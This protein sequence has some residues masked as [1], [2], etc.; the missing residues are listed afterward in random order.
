ME[1][2]K[3][4]RNFRE[5]GLTVSVWKN[6]TEGGKIYYSLSPQ[7][8]YTKD[9]GQTWESTNS[10]SKRESILLANLFTMASTWITLN[11][12]VSRELEKQIQTDVKESMIR[13]KETEQ[14]N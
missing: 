11:L 10:Y 4:V 8:R 6:A 7:K 14:E 2:N 5:G 13:I 3:P 12:E 9:D 1:Q